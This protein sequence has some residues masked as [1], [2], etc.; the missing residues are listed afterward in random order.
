MNRFLVFML[1][2]V[3]GILIALFIGKYMEKPSESGS[4]DEVAI[5][6]LDQPGGELEYQ[7]YEVFKV[8][9]QGYALAHG[10]E[11]EHGYELV[12]TFVALIH[13]PDGAPFYDKQKVKAG[14]E[15]RFRHVGI[16]RQESMH[17]TQTIPVICLSDK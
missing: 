1:G 3:T 13:D 7:E 12:T 16:F 5:Q 2:I 9:G 11:N 17:G 14:G 15:K 10:I 8:L 6:F 4:N